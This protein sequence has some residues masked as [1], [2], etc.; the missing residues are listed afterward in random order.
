MISKEKTNMCQHPI[1]LVEPIVSVINPLKK[2]PARADGLFEDETRIN[3]P[4]V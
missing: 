1:P 2:R 3:T 4:K